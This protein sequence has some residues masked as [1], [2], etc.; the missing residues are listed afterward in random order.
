MKGRDD[1]IQVLNEVL[2]AELT[3]IN[4][5][6]VHAMMCK[7]WGYLRLAERTRK[8][9]VEEMKHAQ[10][11]IERILFLEGTPNMQKYMRIN[12]GATVQEQLT[13]DL[14]VEV[15]GVGRLN[16]GIELRA[17]PGTTGRALLEGILR[18]EEEHIDWLEAQ[19]QQIRDIGIQG[20]LAEQTKE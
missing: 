20:Y 4:Q 15:E 11:V 3:A 13:F 12:V 6:F 8:E 18:E 17:S 14:D 10:L 19:L 1:V 7:N 2:C 5:Y 16:A 9:S